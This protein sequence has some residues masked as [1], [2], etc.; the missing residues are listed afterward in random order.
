[1]STSATI[2]ECG[3]ATFYRSFSTE[4]K[5][6]NVRQL[7]ISKQFRFGDEKIGRAVEH[8]Y[9]YLQEIKYFY[10]N[11]PARKDFNKV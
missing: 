2:D 1:M 11:F 7:L 9:G 3:A 8:F 4:I 6:S 5:M 10:E